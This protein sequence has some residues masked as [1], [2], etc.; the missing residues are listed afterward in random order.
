MVFDDIFDL[1]LQVGFRLSEC[2]FHEPKEFRD[3]H[4]VDEILSID[5]CRGITTRRLLAQVHMVHHL[6]WIAEYANA[7]ERCQESAD[8]T[9]RDLLGRTCRRI[10]A[11]ITIQLSLYI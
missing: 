10:T 5:S 4:V 3:S 6:K 8:S 11:L 9:I 1:E 7:C 2:I